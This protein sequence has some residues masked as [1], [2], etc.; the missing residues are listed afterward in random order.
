MCP[1][2]VDLPGVARSRSLCTIYLETA[3]PVED[4]AG[5]VIRKERRS[6]EVPSG[7]SIFVPIFA[8]KEF[9]LFGEK[10]QRVFRWVFGRTALGFGVRASRKLAALLCLLSRLSGT[11]V[12]TR[13]S[14]SWRSGASA[15]RERV[16]RGKLNE[17]CT[18][19]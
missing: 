16:L 17:V 6:V 10:G 7:P 18:S 2:E 8:D 4:E 5:M 19:T 9:V 14:N 15:L 1:L 12:R 3:R 11:V 13:L